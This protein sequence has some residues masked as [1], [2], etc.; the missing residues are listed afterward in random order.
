MDAMNKLEILKAMG[1]IVNV[2][3][4]L[5]KQTFGY[6][7]TREKTAYDRLE[8]T[9]KTMGYTISEYFKSMSDASNDEKFIESFRNVSSLAAQIEIVKNSTQFSDEEKYAKLNEIFEK[10]AAQQKA[11]QKELAEIHKKKIQ[12]V[13]VVAGTIVTGGIV[14][15]KPELAK[16]SIRLLKKGIKKSPK[17]LAGGTKLIAKSHP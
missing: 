11:A 5:I 15:V 10:Q 7:Q 3:P 8:L 16:G 6:L 1:K 13:T 2:T 12:M 4:N 9:L 17:L 14:M